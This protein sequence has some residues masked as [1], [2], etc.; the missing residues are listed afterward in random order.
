MI[1]ADR[2]GTR[3][4]EISAVL[5]EIEPQIPEVRSLR[6]SP[7]EALALDEAPLPFQDA[8]LTLPTPEVVDAPPSLRTL[9]Y[10]WQVPLAQQVADW[11]RVF[12][13]EGQVAE[14]RALNV[15]M[16]NG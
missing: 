12:V 8:G 16:Q 15:V 7:S 5:P 13:E 14:L 1:V 2:A 10:S 11:L 9:D 6:L 3:N 4:Q